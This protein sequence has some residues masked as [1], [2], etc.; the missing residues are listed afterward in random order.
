M[1]TQLIQLTEMSSSQMMGYIFTLQDGRFVVID[2]G[3]EAET[4]EVLSLLQQRSEHPCVAAWILTH[5]HYDHI[6]AFL[7]IMRS[8][9]D[10]V[11]VERVLH[12]F[13]PL[14]FL[15]KYEAAYDFSAREYEELLPTFADI[16]S[17]TQAG[18]KYTFGELEIEILQT[19]DLSITRNAINNS[20]MVFAVRVA[21]QRL[22]FLGDLSVE[23]GKKLL[24]RYSPEQLH[25]DICQMA[26]HGQNGVTREVYAV[27]A[28]RICLWSTPGWLWDNMGDGGFNTGVWKTVEVR[29][30]MDSLG[31]TEHYVSKDGVHILDLPL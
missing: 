31:V 27:I 10:T 5:A 25:A 18:E 13:P 23:G 14:E 1:Q 24:E 6:T 20:S 26:H 19:P 17:P 4:E 21:G 9:R 15:S 2:G 8:H 29:G 11:T 3:T 16:A 12:N 30:W 28:P 7:K 22:I